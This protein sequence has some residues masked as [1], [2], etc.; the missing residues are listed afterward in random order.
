MS[1]V[2]QK[3][4]LVLAKKSEEEMASSKREGDETSRD[5][6]QNGEGKATAV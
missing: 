5:A 4:A 1:N 6:S 3:N 2:G